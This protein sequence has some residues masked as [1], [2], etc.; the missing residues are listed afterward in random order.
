MSNN[1]VQSEQEYIRSLA[2]L[3]I[4]NDSID[5]SLYT[6]YDVKRGLRDLDGNGVLTGLTEISQVNAKKEVN[7]V[8]VP[9]EGELL[10]RG[11]N[12]NEIV[13]GCLKDNRFGFEET[14]YLLLFGTLPDKRQL[15]LFTAYL[16]EH[17]RLSRSF[18]RDVIM[19]STG[20]NMMNMLARCV[21]ALYPYDSDPDNT[22]VQNVLR[23]SLN[24]ISVL[25]LISVYSYHAK[26]YFRDS[27]SLIIHPPVKELST[28]ENIL[29]TLRA[30][31][32]YTQLEARVLDLA[33]IIH[34]EHG[35]GNNSTFTTRVVSS[36]GTDTYCAISA[37]L[38][39][40]KGPKHGGANIKVTQMFEDLKKS[41]SDWKDDEEIT[42][43]LEKI[44]AKEAF[45]RQGL[46]YG[47]GHAVYSV[48]DPRAE[49]FRGFVEK[50]SAEKGRSDEFDLYRKVELLAPVT[51]AQKRKMYKGVSANVDFYSG[52][53]YQLL[54]LPPELFTPIF[55]ISRV[56]GWSAHRIEELINASKIIRPAYKGIGERK[57][58]IPLEER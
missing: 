28:A 14:V 22:S 12:I 33:L 46:I 29:H 2:D 56:A 11:I 9:C 16:G 47:I 31:S 19:K 48:S 42:R 55:A 32:S 38:G 30:D 53:A 21:L 58:Y 17:R 54:N 10:Y 13:G 20:D 44:L 25:P 27:D 8:L 57:E 15:E 41:V 1:Q 7:G 52:F 26:N 34:A 24:L 51:V 6:K 4:Q 35:G 50:L 40:L 37:A 49:L 23:Q 36:S 18:V 5:L 43:Y 39:S 45:D 3:C